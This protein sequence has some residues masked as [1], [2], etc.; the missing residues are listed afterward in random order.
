[1]SNDLYFIPIIAKALD[2]KDTKESLKKAFE[3]IKSLGS[4]PE[5]EQ[6]FQQFQQFMDVAARKQETDTLDADLVSELIID[7]ATDGFEGSDEDKQNALSIIKSHPRLKKEYDQLVTDIEQLNQR[8]PGVEVSIS[9][10]NKG[11]KSV[12]FMEVPGSKTIDKIAA[13]V[14]NIAFATGELIW[15]GKLTAQDLIWVEAYPGRSFD[16]AADTTGLKPEPTKEISV[17][18]GNILIRVFAGLE[19]GR[20]EITINTMKDSQ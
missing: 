4:M 10:E 14:Y 3:K 13:G 16:L 7:L 15:E 9:R 2:Q 17:F 19:S 5:Y 11:F 1:M 18:D 12:T 6:G 20:I 8:P